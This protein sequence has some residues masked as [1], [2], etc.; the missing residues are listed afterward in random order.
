MT[1]S[2][3]LITKEEIPAIREQLFRGAGFVPTEEELQASRER[4]RRAVENAKKVLKPGDR[5]RVSKC[6]GTKRM[7]TFAGWEGCWIVSKSGIN[8]YAASCVD[9]LNGSPVDFAQSNDQ[10]PGSL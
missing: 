4:F 2:R 1:M 3:V 10:P 6:P 9:M 5:L 7:I 8:D